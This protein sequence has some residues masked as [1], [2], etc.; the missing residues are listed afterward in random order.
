[1]KDRIIKIRNCVGNNGKKM[2]QEEFAKRLNISR[3]FVNQVEVGAKNL[4]DR[5]ILDICREFNVNENWLK[6]GE[7]EMFLPES[8]DDMLAR[9]TVD[10]LTESED[11]FKSRFI[12]LLAKMT[13][14]EW[15]MLEN[16]V[17]KLSKK[18]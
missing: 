1:M 3:S 15:T 2:T 17:E 18:E 10:L 16:M 6:T 14:E 13:D 7:G 9:L 4:S 11:S 12:S 8:K 5:T